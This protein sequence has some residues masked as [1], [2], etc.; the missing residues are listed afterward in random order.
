M[1]LPVILKGDQKIH[2]VRMSVSIVLYVA[3]C[4]KKRFQ[5]TFLSSG[6]EVQSDSSFL[7]SSCSIITQK[8]SDTGAAIQM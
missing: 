3:I 6:V 5:K 8:Y 1:Q 2:K 4:L 7:L